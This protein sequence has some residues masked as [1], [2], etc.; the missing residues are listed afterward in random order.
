MTQQ[1][2]LTMK[3]IFEDEQESL[4]N[5]FAKIPLENPQPLN[6]EF[7]TIEGRSADCIFHS[8]GKR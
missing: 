7:Q 4:I 8:K 1:Y 5:F 3:K 6:I 2:D